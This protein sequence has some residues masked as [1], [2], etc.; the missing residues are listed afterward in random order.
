MPGGRP[1]AYARAA[2]DIVDLGVCPVSVPAIA[3]LLQPCREAAWALDALAPRRK[4][5]PFAVAVTASETGLDVTWS[6]PRA[7]DMADRE[8]LARVAEANDLA[9]VSWR[10]PGGPPGGDN[11]APGAAE[12]VVER[13]KPVVTLGG[14]AVELPPDAFLQATPEGQLAIQEIVGAAVATA[15]KGGVVDLF[16]GCGTLALELA[17]NRAV[18]AVDVDA[19]AVAALEA[20]ARRARLNKL[21]AERRDLARRPLNADELKGFA[22]VVFDPPRA[23]ALAQAQAVARSRVPVV[24]A[25]SCDPATLARDL[26]M[27]ADG[28]YALERVVPIDQFLWSPRIE[29]VAVLR[30]RRTI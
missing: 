19:G 3:A 7:P 28:G 16:A 23:G 30:K 27:L 26:R 8:R 13:R 22:A 12:P 10:L 11:D 4:P 6:L 15:P 2:H 18:L 17:R 20:A 21:T 5:M 9:R 24:A 1:W 29:A 14:A 25:V